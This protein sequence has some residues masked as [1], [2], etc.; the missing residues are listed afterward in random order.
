MEGTLSQ[1]YVFAAA[2]Y[3][4]MALG[5]VYSLLRFIRKVCGDGKVLLVV[6]DVLYAVIITGVTALVCYFTLEMEIRFYCIAAIALG[7]MLWLMA[8]RPMAKY[9][10]CKFSRRRVDKRQEKGSNNSRR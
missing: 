10:Y 1:P 6:T 8:V 5:M 3:A 9:V 2:L 7:M 4:G